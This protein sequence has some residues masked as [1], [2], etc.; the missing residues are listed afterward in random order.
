MPDAD[1]IQERIGEIGRW[2]WRILA[3]LGT[4]AALGAWQ[5]LVCVCR[6]HVSDTKKIFFKVKIL[7]VSLCHSIFLNNFKLIK[8]ET[9]NFLHLTYTLLRPFSLSDISR[10]R[11][12][13]VIFK[14]I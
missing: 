6:S 12:S 7:F 1:Y 10:P 5:T 3:V 14:V 9:S 13:K 4:A 2:Q 11:P 8:I